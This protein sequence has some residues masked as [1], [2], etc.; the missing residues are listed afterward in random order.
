M[1]WW[2]PNLELPPPKSLSDLRA[3]ASKAHVICD[4]ILFE[5]RVAQGARGGV[6]RCEDPTAGVDL[7]T[8][9]LNVLVLCEV[10]DVPNGPDSEIWVH[11]V[12]N[13]LASGHVDLI[14]EVAVSDSSIAFTAPA[15]RIKGGPLVTSTFAVPVVRIPINR[16]RLCLHDAYCAADHKQE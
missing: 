11:R 6:C 3:G 12:F 4:V 13:L 10:F 8:D 7:A 14:G 9:E 1:P 15:G 16:L 5:G 2:I